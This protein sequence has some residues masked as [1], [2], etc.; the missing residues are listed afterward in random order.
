M[1]TPMRPP[2]MMFPNAIAFVVDFTEATP[3]DVG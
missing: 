2:K 3:A 1:P